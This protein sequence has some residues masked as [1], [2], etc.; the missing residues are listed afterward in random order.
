MFFF[1]FQ[2][3]EWNSF[4]KQKK[5]TLPLIQLYFITRWKF[6]VKKRLEYPA[7]EIG[8][9]GGDGTKSMRDAHVATCGVHVYPRRSALAL[10]S[11]GVAGSSCIV[12]SW[13]WLG[14]MY[15]T[16]MR[17]HVWLASSALATLPRCTRNAK[18]EDYA[19]REASFSLYAKK[20]DYTFHPP[21]RDSS[22]A[23]GSA[24]IVREIRDSF[25]GAK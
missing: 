7:P 17:S 18:N 23:I 4:D 11:R 21:H 22:S 16:E 3:T 25:K 6:C 1:F 10:D 13:N 9:R 19:A 14:S 20:N 15:R 24:T 2:K 12:I 8:I 5:C